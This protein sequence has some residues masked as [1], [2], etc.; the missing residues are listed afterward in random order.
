MFLLSSNE[1]ISNSCGIISLKTS[2]NWAEDELVE[3][4]IK[5]IRKNKKKLINT[6]AIKHNNKVRLQGIET[7]DLSGL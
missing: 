1:P 3:V 2:K 5:R 4:V 6:K 7:V